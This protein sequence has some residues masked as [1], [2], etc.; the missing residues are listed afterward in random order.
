MAGDFRNRGRFCFY[1]LGALSC[2][3]EVQPPAEKSP[4]RSQ[5]REKGALGLNGERKKERLCSP[6]FQPAQL[7][8]RPCHPTL[9]SWLLALPP[10][11]P[12]PQAWFS[13]WEPLMPSQPQGTSPEKVLPR[14]SYHSWVSH[15]SCPSPA[16]PP[17][18]CSPREQKN[19]PADPSHFT[20]SQADE[21]LTNL[22]KRCPYRYRNC[23]QN[24]A[25]MNGW[26]FIPILSRWTY[27][28]KLL[29]MYE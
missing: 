1:A 22:K 21:A 6:A 10:S 23:K 16:E 28:N 26:F 27:N 7:S 8:R 3:I 9:W 19:H 11:C 20:E 25:E 4:W 15:L 12:L 17:K 14:R 2:L 29:D 18:D 5:R 13:K 24:K